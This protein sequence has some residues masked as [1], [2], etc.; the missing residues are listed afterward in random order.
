M[1]ICEG[2]MFAFNVGK[3][4]KRKDIIREVA[5]GKL[6]AYFCN[7]YCQRIEN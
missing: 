1:V 6:A 2:Y 5:V 7:T 4:M 3:D